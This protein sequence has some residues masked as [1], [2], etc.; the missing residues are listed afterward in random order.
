MLVDGDLIAWVGSDAEAERHI[1]SADEH[2]RLGGAVVTPGFVDAH[3]HATSTGLT[4]AGL[5]L[6]RSNSLAEAL[7]LLEAAARAAR[8]APILGHGWDE[9]RWPEGRPPTSA[10]VDRASWGSMVYLS[11]IDVHSAVISSALLAEVPGARDLDGYGADGVVS[12]A[13]HHAYREVALRLIGAAQQERAHRETRKRA[14]SLGIVALHEMAGPAISSAD[15]LRGLLG[16]GAEEP[17]PL[18]TGYWGELAE[19]GGVELAIELGAIGAA[20]DLFID[21]A[22][23]SRTACL[24][25]AYLDSGESSG[26]QYL[27]EEQVR[28]HVVACIAAGLQ[29][30][31]HVIGDR[32]T[33]VIMSAMTGAAALLGV[34]TVRAGGHRLEH[35]EMLDSV[36]IAEMARLAMTAS[37]QPMFDGL[38]GADG[39]MYE[40]RLGRDR[41]IGMNR[42]ADLEAAGVLTAFGSDSPVTDLGPWQAVAAA[43]HHHQQGQRM[44]PSAA[45]WA[46]SVAGWRAIGDHQSGG[47]APGAP[48]HYVIW[49]S[50]ADF[51]ASAPIPIA[52]RTVV[53]GTIVHDT[54][55]IV[56]GTGS[57]VHGTGSA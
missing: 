10:E 43:V 18:V 12:R 23:G 30:G 40:Q 33:D 16:L 55:A 46:H 17:G 11:R 37:V 24:R 5:D 44:S 48:A 28:D 2:H 53:A 25:H 47:L 38:W 20:G 4:L 1:S 7:S 39:G 22:I 35:A 50:A 56:H 29:S 52:L 45:F 13:A 3:V 14:A 42:F 21:G 6:T 51:D 41:S 34:D 31:F 32:A 54:G 19:S 15:D 57:I 49:D 27:S 26:A 9:T 8:G 36:H